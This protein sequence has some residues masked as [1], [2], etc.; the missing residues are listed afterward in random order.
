M[1]PCL[2]LLTCGTAHVTIIVWLLL[3][4]GWV[5][6][7]QPL[8][9]ALQLILVPVLQLPHQRGGLHLSR[10]CQIPLQVRLQRPRPC[11]GGSWPGG[12][13][14][15][16]WRCARSAMHARWNQDL[17]RRPHI[18]AL[19]KQDGLSPFQVHNK[20][21][22]I[23]CSLCRSK[24]YRRWLALRHEALAMLV[25]SSMHWAHSASS[26]SKP[27][28][29]HASLKD[30]CCVGCCKC[31]FV[32]ARSSKDVA[33]STWCSKRRKKYLSPSEGCTKYMRPMGNR[34]GVRV[35]SAHY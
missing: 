22:D 21:N 32:R 33:P 28:C 1:L 10:G 23:G 35:R 26:C 7:W 5:C 12:C 20:P 14:C 24:A 19:L 34:L 9:G 30:A 31:L 3:L 2:R 25:A 16:W 17:P 15:T 18:S 13:C 27:R 11:T 4:Q 6:L 29:W 8:G